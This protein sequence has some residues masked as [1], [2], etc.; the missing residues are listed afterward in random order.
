MYMRLDLNI[1]QNHFL[2]PLTAGPVYITVFHVLL[3]K[4]VTIKRN[5]NQQDFKIADLYF[6]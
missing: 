4:H 1:C 6:V 3:L 2:I 5:I